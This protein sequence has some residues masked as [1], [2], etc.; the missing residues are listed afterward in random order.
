MDRE[1]WRAVCMGLQ[2][3]GHDG[4]TELNG[5]FLYK[6]LFSRSAVSNSL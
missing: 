6:F 1:A 5:T 3:I 4:A 2:S